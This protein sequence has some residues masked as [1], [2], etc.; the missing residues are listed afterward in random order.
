MCSRTRRDG[1]E[2]ES[3]EATLSTSRCGSPR[4]SVSTDVHTN[5]DVITSKAWTAL[6]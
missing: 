5:D 4:C 1:G 3:D 2:D 6:S